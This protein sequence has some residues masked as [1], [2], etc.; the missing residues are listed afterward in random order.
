VFSTGCVTSSNTIGWRPSCKCNAPAAPAIVLD[1]FA[2][3][4]TTLA[5]A[6]SLGHIGIGYELSTEYLPMIKERLEATPSG[7]LSN[8]LVLV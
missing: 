4:G 1:P 2:G 5:V 7:V 6:K 3:S 8:Q